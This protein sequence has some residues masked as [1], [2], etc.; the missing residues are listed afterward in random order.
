[1][2]PGERKLLIITTARKRDGKEWEK[3]FE[4]YRENF[5]K[6]NV[7][8]IVDSWNNIKKYSEVTG[9]FIIFDEQ[10][11]VSNGTWV[12]TFLKLARFNRWILLTAT[13]GDT[14][15]DY[16]PVFVA[17]GFYRNRTHFLNRH[18]IFSRFTTYPKVERYV[19]ENVLQKYKSKI[20]VNMEYQRNIMRN[21]IYKKVSYDEKLYRSALVNRWNPFKNEPEVNAGGMCYTLR[22][23]VN[24]SLEHIEQLRSLVLKKEKAII[25]Y[26]FDYELEAIRKVLNEEK[27]PFG[28][29]NGHKHEEIPES[30]K[31]CYLVQYAA[32]AEA[33]N[34]IKT[35]TIIFFSL[36]YSYKV[37]TQ[38]A[39]RI[40][41][42][43]SPFEEL[44]YYYIVSD[45]PIDKAIQAALKKKK[46]FNEKDFL[47]MKGDKC[48]AI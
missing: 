29:W 33:W 4:N 35:N 9:A 13:P 43:N 6:E 16:I 39:G 31:W 38:A 19:G 1:M 17:N 37:M 41:R 2:R 22:K 5:E 40:D 8:V 45:S 21:Y 10:R 25:F 12:R 15:L 14:W 23:I 32:G 7:S 20:L 34:C 44:D 24:S 46:N 47:S 26:N 36:N 30:E 11:L 42:V 3:E 18:V 27:I 28:E 48:G